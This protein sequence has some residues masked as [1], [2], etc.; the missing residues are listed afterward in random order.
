MSSVPPLAK[1]AEVAVRMPWLVVGSPGLTVP[2]LTVMAPAVPVP[3]RMAPLLTATALAVCV[4]SISK[5]PPL[6]VVVPV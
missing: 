3:P 1:L 2:L 6:T 4:P 5:V